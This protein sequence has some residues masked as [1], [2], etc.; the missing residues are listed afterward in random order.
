MKFLGDD[1]AASVPS[2]TAITGMSPEERKASFFHKP[3]RQRAAIVAA[4]PIANFILAIVIFASIF[5]LFG[6]QTTTARVDAVQ[7]DS[8]AAAAGLQRATSSSPST[9][10]RSRASRTCSELSAPV[11]TARWSSGST[12]AARRSRS[13][14]A[15]PQAGQ[16]W[17]R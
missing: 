14:P 2:Q 12:A 5:A 13:M 10:A 6:K 7:P 9:A 8:P 16:G 11:P 15:D 3:V 1:N 4:G 17:L